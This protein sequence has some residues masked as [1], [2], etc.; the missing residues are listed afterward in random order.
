MEST[1]YAYKAVER[2]LRRLS[3][4]ALPPMPQGCE[5]RVL[6][7][8]EKKLVEENRAKALKFKG[9][10]RA[11]EIVVGDEATAVQMP[12]DNEED[13]WFKA[14]CGFDDMCD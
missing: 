13:P 3:G 4:K 6:T 1:A 2:P 7:E 10:G 9:S 5:K 8:A 11:S 14:G 12:V